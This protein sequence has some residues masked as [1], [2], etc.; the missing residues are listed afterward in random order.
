[1]LFKVIKIES[2]ILCFQYN[3]LL[4]S[5]QIKC[6]KILIYLLRA[7]LQVSFFK[8]QIQDYTIILHCLLYFTGNQ[9]LFF[10][11]NS[12]ADVLE[13]IYKGH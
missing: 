8:N 7:I 12:P 2:F 3:W 11:N 6:I 13:H 5:I 10:F 4:Y 1:M 9:F